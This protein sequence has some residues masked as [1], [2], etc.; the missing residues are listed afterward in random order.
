MQE[1]DELF[2][3]VDQCAKR[4]KISERHFRRLV[5]NGEMPKPMKLG[6]STRWSLRVIERL[7][8]LQKSVNNV[9][10]KSWRR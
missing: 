10:L 6:R 3:T 2:L 8:G 1:S 9:T 4:Y 5:D 7:A